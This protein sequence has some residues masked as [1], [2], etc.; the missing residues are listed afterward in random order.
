MRSLTSQLS[1]KIIG[2]SELPVI[3]SLFLRG[4]LEL[5]HRVLKR[6]NEEGRIARC[7]RLT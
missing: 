6:S 1:Y 2:R 4:P 5:A 3:P 7:T